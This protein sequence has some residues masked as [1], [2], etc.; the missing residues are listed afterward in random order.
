[1]PLDRY[2]FE[3]RF[4]MSSGVVNF[5]SHLGDVAMAALDKAF[6]RSEDAPTSAHWAMSRIA[7]LLFLVE[8]AV[9]AVW[10]GWSRR[11]CRYVALALATPLCLLYFGSWGLGFLAIAVGV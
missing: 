3:V 5:H 11:V 9:A 4:S 7:G 1:L 10:H 2:S 6:G 8:L